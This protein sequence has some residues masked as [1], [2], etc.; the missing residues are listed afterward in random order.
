MSLRIPAWRTALI[1]AWLP[2][3]ACGRNQ[4]SEESTAK[5]VK[6]EP[7]AGDDVNRLILTA[8]AARRLDIQTVGVRRSAI[9]GVMRK[10]VPYAAILYDAEG[11][12]WTYTN[13]EP[14]VY[15]RARVTV[16]SVTGDLAVL[17]T[18]PN[19]GESVVTVGAAELFGSEE[20]FEEE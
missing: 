15:I 5:A 3:V 6:V 12:A 16:E 18:G 7:V 19:P 14:F 20:E 13:P 10:L 11:Q 17:S 4:A 1:V 9:N 8:D 2:L